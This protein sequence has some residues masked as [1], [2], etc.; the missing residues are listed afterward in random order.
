MTAPEGWWDWYREIAEAMGYSI[1]R[2]REA[3]RLL[4]ELLR[5]RPCLLGPLRE[6]MEERG[7]AVV[8]GAADELSR[9]ARSLATL[10]QRGGYLLLAADGAAGGLMEQ[11]LV[12]DIV[13]TDLDGGLPLLRR[14][15]GMGAT[16]FIH[17]HGDNIPYLR[18]AAESFP[19]RA[20]ATCQ[21]EPLGHIHNLGGFT[22]GD[23]AVYIAAAL[24]AR[25]IVT[26]GMCLDC[27]VGAYSKPGVRLSGEW[28][29]AKRRKMW[30]AMRL[31][32][33]LS[34]VR[35]DIEFID[36]SLSSSSIPG[37]ERRLIGD[38]LGAP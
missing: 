5:E 36:A 20:E 33:W 30:Y 14:A 25:R 3:A 17:A 23:R 1:E 9:D 7:V 32:T 4:G 21:C 22:D 2:D 10:G 37:F 29:R 24:G 18:G 27:G 38:A 15:W 26:I 12:P 31:L 8:A 6:R 34:E 11:G 19:E 28:L 13:V 35:R 16:L